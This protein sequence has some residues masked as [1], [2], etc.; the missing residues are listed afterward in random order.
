MY[1][2]V[3]YFT[4]LQDNEHS[5][6]A[7]DIFP[8]EGMKVTKTRLNELASTKNARGIALIELVEKTITT[9]SKKKAKKKNA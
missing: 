6:H 2:V 8:R 4:D 7:G 3:K 5:Y 9:D 1:R